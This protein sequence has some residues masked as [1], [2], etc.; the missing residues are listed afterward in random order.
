MSKS[1]E[2]GHVHVDIRERVLPSGL[3]LIAAHNP[4][5]KT[6]ATAV[7]LK[8]SSLD[9]RA[10]EEGLAALTGGCLDE[11][12]ARRTGDELAQAVES[13]GGSMDSSAA[14]GSVQCPAENL[15]SAI[16]LLDE[17]VFEPSFPEAEV[18]RVR[19]ETLAEIESE[20]HEP[21]TVARR[22]FRSL[23]YGDH[24][25]AR[26]SYGS[27]EHVQAVTPE[28]L[29]AFHERQFVV[30]KGIVATCGPEDPDKA[31]DLL[32]KQFAARGGALSERPAFD[33]APA[34][35]AKTDEHTA[36]DR[37]QV[38]VFVGH[39]GIRRMDPDYH[40]LL[41][42]DHVLGTGPGFT[43]R[44][45]KKLRDER[46]LCY[47][48]SAAIASSAGLE[49]GTFTAYIGTSPEHR[50]E[51]VDGFLDEMRAIRDG[52]PTA[53]ELED[54]QDY[55]TGSYVFGLERNTQLVSYAVRCKRFGLPYDEILRYPDKIR[56]IT[57]EDV[58]RAAQDHL[59]PDTVAIVS[60]GA[61]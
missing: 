24:P 34:R 44:I 50:T 51:S 15:G 59:H 33:S 42:M 5:S 16:A 28:R 21:R 31:L 14:G 19:D 57:V 27:A 9:E 20:Q 11:G 26:P 49:P 18:Q 58:R 17:C 13:L 25:F 52:V 7:N 37:E 12:T 43:S 32:E 61:G 41:V 22:R 30:Q 29:R 55:L 6:C 4:T 38:H 48:V 8:I 3:I 39:L 54:V 45:T 46:G 1:T 47:S 56:A 40:A 23:I 10:G 2:N 53:Q 36:M 35:D 60:A